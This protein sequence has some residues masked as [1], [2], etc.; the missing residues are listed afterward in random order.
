MPQCSAIRISL[1]MILTILA[2]TAKAQPLNATGQVPMTNPAIASFRKTLGTMGLSARY[3]CMDM[4]NSQDI[5]LGGYHTDNADK[6]FPLLSSFTQG[7]DHKWT[8]LFGP[9]TIKNF[10][11]SAVTTIHTT[12]D[13]D[14]LA[15]GYVNTYKSL[16]IQYPYEDAFVA[17]VSATGDIKWLMTYDRN[18]M[19]CSRENL[20]R[21]FLI[22]EGVRNEIIVAAEMFNCITE[23][24]T[25]MVFKLDPSGKVI[26]SSSYLYPISLAYRSGMTLD[27]NGITFWGTRPVANQNGQ[28][29]LDQ[30]QFDYN[31]GNMISRRSWELIS[32]PNDPDN[33]FGG[34]I[35]RTQKMNNGNMLVFGTTAKAFDN[36][37]S[38]RAH[39]TIL[40]FNAAY[41][42]IQGYNIVPTTKEISTIL[43]NITSD[44]NGMVL[45]NRLYKKTSSSYS[46]ALGTAANRTMIHE[47]VFEN[48]QS[49]LS[50][51][52]PIY[53]SDDNSFSFLNMYGQVIDYYTL[54]NDD[55]STGCLGKTNTGE[56]LF[57]TETIQY[58]PLPVTLPPINLD[59]I[60]ATDN[61]FHAELVNMQNGNRLDLGIDLILCKGSSITLSAPEG[62]AS[63][64]WNNGYRGAVLIASNPGLYYCTVTDYC[65]QRY[66][67]TIMVVDNETVQLIIADELSICK[68][69]RLEVNAEQGFLRYRWGP[70]YNLVN[71][72]AS[73]S[74]IAKPAMDTVYYVQAE[75]NTGCF[76]YDTVRI[77]IKQALSFTLG[78]DKSICPG[79]SILLSASGIFQNYVWSDGTRSANFRVKKSGL[80]SLTGITAD[81]C[82]SSDTVMIT[83]KD[84][85]NSFFMPNAFT[86]NGDGLNDIIKPITKG[87]LVQYQMLIYNRWGELVF[88][89]TD[90]SQGWNGKLK[91]II[92]SPQTYTWQCVWQVEGGELKRNYGS[93]TLIR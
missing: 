49:N 24:Q 83:Q 35:F 86:P 16:Q 40:E 53:F 41:Q 12:A 10:Q 50:T 92:Q 76:I 72:P 65:G 29:Y 60:I 90:L 31:N 19:E 45:F 57:K 93:L 69:D 58:R 11:I 8:L 20:F 25:L 15:A 73:P 3:N 66:S 84:C 42:F 62:F 6:R 67:D 23:A 17:R 56:I 87:N 89:S 82:S 74:L 78:P 80:Y 46:Y 18:K 34:N 63:Y 47:R 37:L 91:G 33:T 68:D 38:S 22:S 1:A 28:N 27:G 26:W 36:S 30:L 79:D 81:G 5:N 55:I 51:P 64:V 21:P 32:N 48:A 13:G 9:G 44:K 71:N 2:L 14:I 85:G 39:F 54:N 52:E 4:A 7:G 61:G 77:K 43:L 88:S 59:T 70:E 75:N